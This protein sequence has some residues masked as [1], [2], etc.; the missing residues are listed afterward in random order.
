MTP[1]AM[2]LVS[3]TTIVSFASRLRSHSLKENDHDRNVLT[4]LA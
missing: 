4:Q 3:L 2:E 1:V